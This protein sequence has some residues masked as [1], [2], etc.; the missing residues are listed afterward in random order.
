MFSNVS[1]MCNIH[2]GFPVV[3]NSQAENQFISGIT[4]SLPHLKSVNY[5]Y[6]GNVDPLYQTIRVSIDGSL[7]NYAS[8]RDEQLQI[9]SNKLQRL[10]C[11][12]LSPR[13]KH[14]NTA[15]CSQTHAAICETHQGKT[16][17]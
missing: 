11:T 7:T 4:T 5:W 1:H 6:I 16:P 13:D 2:G 12:I 14:W 10:P 15:H 9:E 8:W 17:Q 3:I